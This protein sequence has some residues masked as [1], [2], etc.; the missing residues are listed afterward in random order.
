MIHLKQCHEPWAFLTK[1][2]AMGYRSIL[3]MERTRATGWGG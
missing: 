3:G 1:A 2:C